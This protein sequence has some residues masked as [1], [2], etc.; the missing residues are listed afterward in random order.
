MKLSDWWEIYSKITQD[1]LFNPHEDY[2]SSLILSTRI[3][4]SSSA[5]F[6]SL[7]SGR[8]VTV[9]GN[10]PDLPKL[11]D[12]LSSSFF[13]VADSAIS[14]FR[15]CVG[16]PEV[17]VSDLDGNLDDIR[18]CTSEKSSLVIHAH[19]DNMA[20]VSEMEFSAIPHVVGTTQNIPLWNLGNYGGF[21]DGDRAAFLADFFGAESITL[22][23]FDFKSPN[24]YKPSNP[25]VKKR[26]LEW[27]RFL[28]GI[29][30]E[31]RGTDFVEGNFIDI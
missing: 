3:G 14:V 13:I 9:V 12:S 20:R 30:A 19:G 26:K 28:L 16:C 4:Y 24:P 15:D 29:L 5:Q 25:A 21:T 2:V 18:I 10:G 22:A 27:A 23:G 6:L 31:K 11:T 17:I 1:F 8:K 7:M